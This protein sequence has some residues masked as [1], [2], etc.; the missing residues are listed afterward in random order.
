MASIYLVNVDTVPVYVQYFDITLIPAT[1][2]FFNAQ[3]IKVDWGYVCIQRQNKAR[4]L[5]Q[6]IYIVFL[7]S[8][9]ACCFVLHST[10]DNTKFIGSFATKQDFIDV[11]ETVYRGAMRGKLMVKSPLGR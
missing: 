10:P 11:V 9:S 6:I 4:L 5:T 8:I 1:L 2:F 3:H 7:F